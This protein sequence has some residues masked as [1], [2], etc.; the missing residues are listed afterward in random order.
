LRFRP[1]AL[2][3]TP[4][5][6]G[7]PA[8]PFEVVN[9]YKDDFLEWTTDDWDPAL[10]YWT[11]HFDR[12]LTEWLK[13]VDQS[14]T[15]VM[16]GREFGKHRRKFW[17]FDRDDLL[18]NHWLDPLD[19]A[20]QPD[21]KLRGTANWQQAKDDAWSV[22]L[23]EIE[24]LQQLMQDDRDRYLAEIEMQADNGP[25]YIVAF[26]Q[27]NSVRFPWTLELIDCGL[28]I[29][30]IAYS[31]YKAY[32]K[33]VRPSFLCPGLAPPFG[34]PGHPSFPSGHSF[35]GHLMALLLLEVP[36]IAQRYGMF[37]LPPRPPPPPPPAQ[38]PYPGL[39]GKKVEPYPPVQISKGNPA[40]ITLKSSGLTSHGLG[41]GESIAFWSTDPDPNNTTLPPEIS[42]GPTDGHP[43][44]IYYVRNVNLTTDTFQISDTLGGTA[45]KASV[46][47]TAYTSLNPL[48][49]R[50]EIN[51]PLLWLSQR[52]AKNR[53]RL[54]VHYMS[55]SMGS[56]HLAA[57]LWRALLHE[58]IT[59]N[60]IVCPTLE[61]VINHAKAEWP[62][63]W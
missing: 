1:W 62:T 57:R 26:I 14:R 23:G 21:P 51:S 13:S 49:G 22:I 53:E 44:T 6:A 16:A 59:A 32:F 39:P 7:N 37:D 42:P 20:W 34:P 54:G 63:K 31:Y 11:L 8:Y 5:D 35:L 24:E 47:G 9:P 30:N 19:L 38:P 55:D 15:Y 33:R 36:G 40:T 18:A 43:G 25:D 45:V 28:A 10:R 2:D 3:F 27:A 60:R 50:G 29:G 48:M 12:Q 4:D 41:G 46:D 61:T 17:R 56:R 58:R 52:L